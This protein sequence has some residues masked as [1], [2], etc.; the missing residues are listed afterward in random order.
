MASKKVAKIHNELFSAGDQV[1]VITGPDDYESI[2]KH[3]GKQGTVTG[4]NGLYQVSFE[5]GTKTSL[6]PEEIS[7]A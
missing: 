2:R 6:F 3:I 7:K 4:Y 1:I 5:D